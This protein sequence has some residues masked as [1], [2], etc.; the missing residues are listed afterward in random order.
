MH[1]DGGVVGFL[2]AAFHWLS[3]SWIEVVMLA[4]AVGSI[5]WNRHDPGG[6]LA[7]GSLYT[8]GIASIGQAY[9]FFR[10]GFF[11]QHDLDDIIPLS[12]SGWVGWD[13]VQNFIWGIWLGWFALALLIAG[14]VRSVLDTRAWQRE[15][16]FRSD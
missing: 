1:F 3:W 10:F 16:G 9:S 8:V 13:L 6:S 2:D 4:I 7:F 5:T 15:K 12:P 11:A 14:L